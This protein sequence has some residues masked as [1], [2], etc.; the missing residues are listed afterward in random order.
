MPRQNGGDPV[1][2]QFVNVRLTGGVNKKADAHQLSN[3]EL[4]TADNVVFSAVDRQVTKRYGFQAITPLGAPFQ[5][6]PFKALGCRD[7]VEPLVLGQNTLN[8]YNAAQNLSTAIPIQTQCRL[9]LQQ[10]TASSG[11]TAFAWPPSHASIA[12]DGQK[13]I[14]AVWQEPNVLASIMYYGVQDIATGNWIISPRYVDNFYGFNYGSF[15]FVGAQMPKA[16]YYNGFFYISVLCAGQKQ[17]NTDN[18][19]PT[20]QYDSVIR[21]GELD[22]TNLSGGFALTGFALEIDGDASQAVT[23][24]PCNYA[25]D[26]HVANG[27]WI[28]S[29][30]THQDRLT[31]AWVGTVTT[32]TNSDGSTYRTFTQTKKQNFSFTAAYSP[33]APN[34]VYNGLKFSVKCDGPSATPF[35][36]L[37]NC[38]VVIFDQGSYF[39][40][41]KTVVDIYGNITYSSGFFNLEPVDCMWRGSTLYCAF[42]GFGDKANVML[43]SF[44]PPATASSTLTPITMQVGAPPLRGYLI[45]ILSRMFVQP[46]GK[47]TLW[48]GAGA[49]T[50]AQVYNTAYCLEFDDPTNQGRPTVVARTVART[51]YLQGAKL[52]YGDRP[53]PCDV[54]RIPNTGKFVTLL[55]SLTEKPGG[56]QATWRGYGTLNRVTLE[57][58]PR[59]QVQVL[60]LPTGGNLICGAYPLYYDGAKVTEAGFSAALDNTAEPA[61]VD[62]GGTT[63]GLPVVRTTGGLVG[64]TS[65]VTQSGYIE[66]YYVS[67]LCRRDAYGNVYR[68]APSQTYTAVCPNPN[69][70]VY[71]S[72]VYYN[73]GAQYNDLAQDVYFEFYRST[74]GTPGTYYYIGQCA[75]GGNF[76]DTQPD[77]S[78]LPSANTSITKNRTVYTNANE[79]PND[80][81]P[82][83]HH[84]V[85]SES[86][87]FLIPADNRNLVWYSKQFAPGRTVEFSAA[88]TMSEGL[89]SGQ[90]EALAVLDANLIVFKKDQILYTYGN[91]PDNTG[92]G[93]SFSPFQKIASDVG[94]IDPGSVAQIP[95]GI[96]FRSRR[97]IELLTRGLEVQYIG[98]PVEPLVQAM[99]AISSVVC[100]PGF[101]ELRFVPATA[102][103]PVLCFD[104]G[105]NRWSTFSNMASVQAINMIGT[106]WHIASDGSVVNAETPGVYLDNGA[107]I[108]MTLETPEI[109]VGAG[110][111]QGWGR[112][113]RMALLGDFTSALSPADYALTVQFAYDHSSVY[114]DAIAFST[115]MGLISG[116]A[117]YQFRASRLP[118]QVMQTMRLKITDTGVS[119][120]AC[121][122]S[123]LAL[124]VGSKN[125]LAKLAAT[126]TVGG[127]T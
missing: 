70:S 53:W 35:A 87:V 102:G 76:T 125:G 63:F 57:F 2:K 126:K 36:V 93:G 3:G 94:C 38:C 50:S 86:R 17:T 24:S 28:C 29:G 64:G 40:Y 81:P 45:Q 34:A 100:M 16:H 51:L 90:F 117:V 59:R 84:A 103:Q 124:E 82:A 42:N 1:S 21:L 46:S 106:Y 7:N 27:L 78:T 52:A 33:Y 123:D 6:G 9:E 77:G 75:N 107:P 48:V 15:T 108:V 60:S 119:G 71:F 14:L 12:S 11:R 5:G 8:R 99:G 54:V 65:F 41:G 116:D 32:Q 43:W 30:L 49:N 31:S 110:G 80:P 104:Y 109:P 56:N 22:L 118:R 92:S 113:Y 69:N 72:E 88:L 91:G 122:I 83:I 18:T 37:T 85:A 97:G 61:L 47:V 98:T 23:S 39:S 26:M 101:T 95:A 66:Y 62:Y 120:Q 13:Y 55:S 4:L 10:Q 127:V 44:V 111:A 25:Y 96:V 89:N 20:Y 112:A 73:S 74:Q 67:C 121:G 105:A 115:A 58:T 79:L 19:N 114:T 68:S